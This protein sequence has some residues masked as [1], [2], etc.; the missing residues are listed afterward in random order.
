MTAKVLLDRNPSPTDAQ[1]REGMAGALC[2]CMTYYRI[3]A[4]IKRAATSIAAAGDGFGQGRCSMTTFT[5]IPNRSKSC[6]R[7]G[8]GRSPE[9]T[10]SRARACSS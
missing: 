2:R 9:G 3:Q 6:W 1:I 10:S 5:N 8:T 4:A 7:S